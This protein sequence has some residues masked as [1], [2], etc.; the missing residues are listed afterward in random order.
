MASSASVIATLL[1]PFQC[2]TLSL[3]YGTALRLVM[4]ECHLLHSGIPGRWAGQ[5]SRLGCA[6]FRGRSRICSPRRCNGARSAILKQSCSSR[7]VVKRTRAL[8][9]SSRFKGMHARASTWC[10]PVLMHDVA[11]LPEPRLG[12]CICQQHPSNAHRD[13]RAEPFSQWVRP[14]RGL[15]TCGLLSCSPLCT[16]EG[17]RS[18]GSFGAEAS[19]SEGK[20]KREEDSEPGERKRPAVRCRCL[21]YTAQLPCPP[22]DMTRLSSPSR[23]STPSPWQHD[24]LLHLAAGGM[25]QFKADSSKLCQATFVHDQSSS[26]T[27]PQTSHDS[28]S[29]CRS[30]DVIDSTYAGTSR[31]SCV[32]LSR[33][34]AQACC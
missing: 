9:R 8:C 17:P 22:H 14:S 29:L 19:S 7:H 31:D 6:C 32:A 27:L 3:G 1:L 18:R 21:P 15:V 2:H 33:A 25:C 4:A 34:S 20:R 10:I 16:G 24:L 30:A 13:A 5:Q 26:S 12:V 11:D 28:L 23:S